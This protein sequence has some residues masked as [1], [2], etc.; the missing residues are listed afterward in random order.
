MAKTGPRG[1][2]RSGTSNVPTRERLVQAAIE[3]LKEEGFA[4]AS[5]RAIA[6][7]AGVNQALVF[8]HFGTVN[9]LLLAALDATSE[10][11]MAR[12]Q[13]A[14]ASATGPAELIAAARDIY[15]EDLDAGHLTVLGA[16]IAGASTVPELGPALTERLQPWIS[17]AAEH[18]GRMLEGSPLGA[19]VP[20]DD[21]AFAIVAL[22]LGMELL[23]ALDG[24][25]AQAE[26]LFT[27]LERLSAPLTALVGSPAAQKGRSHA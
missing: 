17:F 4:G 14:V 20:A 6:A 9:D 11:R 16:V 12:Y 10:R 22:Y 23:T 1:H 5:A 2:L 3:T 19:L 7:A 24:N 25:Q 18:V 21:A 13:E 8:Y 27:A 26:S 15:R